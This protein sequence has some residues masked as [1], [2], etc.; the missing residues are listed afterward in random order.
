MTF[1]TTTVLR[2]QEEHKRPWVI[3]VQEANARQMGMQKAFGIDTHRIGL[4][5]LTTDFFPDLDKPDHGIRGRATDHLQRVLTRRFIE[6]AKD[7]TL[8]HLA[9]PPLD[10]PNS[11]K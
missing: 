11:L 10:W 2:R 9:G 1:Y 8:L 4:L 7:P 3:E 5:K 6:A